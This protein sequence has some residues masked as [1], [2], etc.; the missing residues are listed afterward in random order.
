MAGMYRLRCFGETISLFIR[1]TSYFASLGFSDVDFGDEGGSSLEWETDALTNEVSGLDS[2]GVGSRICQ[3][4]LGKW[5]IQIMYYCTR[6]LCSRWRHRYQSYTS[7]VL[8]LR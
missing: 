6:R 2:V 1:D 4:L 5:I 7:S 8:N 3:R